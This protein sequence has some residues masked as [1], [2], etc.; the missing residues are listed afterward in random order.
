MSVPGQERGI[1][2]VCGDE[3]AI[4]RLLRDDIGL[5]SG[6][7]VG[8]RIDELVGPDGRDKA[9]LFLAE[10]RDRHAAYDWEMPILVGGE[11][12][13]LHFSGVSI[14]GGALVMAALSRAGL[15]HLNDESLMRINSEQA[16]LLRATAKE[17]ALARDGGAG[18]G[19]GAFEELSRL[20]NEL[21]NVQRELAKK[22]AELQ[23]YYDAAEE[24]QRIASHLM[25]QLVRADRL[26]DPLLRY[27]IEPARKL[28]GDLIAAA[29]TPAGVLHVLLA[30]GTGHGLA[31]SLNVL[32]MV[33]PFYTMTAKGLGIGTIAVEVNGKLKRWLPVGRFVAAA[34]VAYDPGQGTV[35]VWCGG[36]PP[37]FL[38]DG[39]GDVVHEFTSRHTALGVLQQQDFR[40]ETEVV[41]LGGAYQLIVC[42]DGA[43]EAEG[44]AG[45][46]FGHDGLLRTLRDAP[47][48]ERL[49]R[50]KHDLAQ[51]CGGRP[52]LDDISVVIVE[53]TG[54][55]R[56]P[57]P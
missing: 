11:F 40:P 36:V 39:S 21:V 52:A 33:D 42:S 25:K 56:E 20:N 30:D 29:R 8:S 17:L 18:H 31:A 26:R 54:A 47:A 57:T 55:A 24:E 19:A 44:P 43:T 48:G 5:P 4:L 15:A 14:D 27:W 23:R 34:L 28:S 51:H 16:N 41:D 50:L 37:P 1:V 3:G 10:V 45:V 6:S 22:T 35:E 2:L 32:P 49:E 12:L 38:V 9:A 46:P 53:C 13:P 7:G